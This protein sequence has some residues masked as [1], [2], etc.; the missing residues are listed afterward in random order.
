MDFTEARKGYGCGS[1]LYSNAGCGFELS[2]ATCTA[3]T[4]GLVEGTVGAW[5][6][7]L[8]SPYGNMQVGAQYEYVKRS[9]FSGLGSPKGTNDTIAL[10]SSRYA[11]LQ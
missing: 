10:V 4:S 8:H 9:I 2:A 7:L 5:W 1:P 11:P 6:R 3:N